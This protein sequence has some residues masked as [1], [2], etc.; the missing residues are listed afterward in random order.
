MAL[1]EIKEI[2]RRK[3]VERSALLGRY[4][5]GELSHLRSRGALRCRV[6]GKGL[7]MGLELCYFDGQPATARA[8]TV[9]KAMLRNGFILLPE[10][11]DANVVAF[12]PPL[13]ISKAQ[14]KQTVGVLKKLLENEDLSKSRTRSPVW[15]GA[16]AS[17]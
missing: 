17:R 1:A 4:L 10:G 7:L 2:G 16:R 5:K 15:V 12:T 11:E 13:T 3:L 8:L 14:L 9:I 6:R